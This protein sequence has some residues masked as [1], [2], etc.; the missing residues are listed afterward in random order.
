MK[1]R[2]AN[3]ILSMINAYRTREQQLREITRAIQE[4]PKTGGAI[5]QIFGS[6]TV[7]LTS[8]VALSALNTMHNDTSALI[9]KSAMELADHGISIEETT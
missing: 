1:T 2:P 6:H 5:L 8:N 9:A 7:Q 4:L 3:E